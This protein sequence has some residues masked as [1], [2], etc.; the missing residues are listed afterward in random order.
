[1][2]S[3]I[4]SWPNEKKNRKNKVL[5]D[6]LEEARVW[7]PWAPWYRFRPHQIYAGIRHLWCF[8]AFC[9]ENKTRICSKPTLRASNMDSDNMKKKLNLDMPKII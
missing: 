7:A 6:N 5:G 9:Y 3:L 8:L 2:N 4:Q 1:M